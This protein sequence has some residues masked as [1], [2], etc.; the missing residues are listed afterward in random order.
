VRAI[1]GRLFATTML[2]VCCLL[3]VGLV[4][5]RYF[6][7]EKRWWKNDL[8]GEKRQSDVED[9]N[10]IFIINMT[11]YVIALLPM[12]LLQYCHVERH[13]MLSKWLDTKQVLVLRIKRKNFAT[14][15]STIC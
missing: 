11:H 3:F 5:D 4:V 7:I 9:E 10:L 2:L 12:F 1:T 14:V 8:G 15:V 6:V 13:M